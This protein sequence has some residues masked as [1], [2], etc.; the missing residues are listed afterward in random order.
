MHILWFVD[1]VNFGSQDLFFLVQ[2][3]LFMHKSIQRA[4]ICVKSPENVRECV[5]KYGRPFNLLK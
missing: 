5:P 3:E 4:G 2:R 1:V